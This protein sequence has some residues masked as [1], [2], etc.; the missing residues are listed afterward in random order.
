M[1]HSLYSRF[2]GTLLGARVGT[3]LSDREPASQGWMGASELVTAC[4]IERGY[5]RLEDWKHLQKLLNIANN[6][7]KSALLPEIML[8]L[9]PLA[10]FFHDTPSLFG[11]QL[12]Q[13]VQAWQLS[14]EEWQIL[15]GWGTLLRLILLEKITPRQ[16]PDQW[17]SIGNSSA[18]EQAIALV[19][20]AWQAGMPLTQLSRQ[21]K[22]YV[23][24]VQAALPL[25]LYCWG[26]TPEDFRLS[27]LRSRKI[28][29]EPS[30]ALTGALSGAYN[31]VSGIFLPWCL[32][33]NTTE[34]TQ[35]LAYQLPR[36]WAKWT[37]I[38]ATEELSPPLERAVASPQLLQP[39]LSLKLI[40]HI[41]REQGT[42]NRE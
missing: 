18:F 22:R 25:A 36:L 14:L 8:A 30:V 11:E 34:M 9:L 41:N 17:Q 16:I 19:E 12:E 29:F 7:Q 20:P 4:V 6:G 2:Q 15:Q 37:G 3:I 40:S 32:A 28:G 21:L 5:L 33:L 42:G 35:T 26:D 1:K 13:G 23:S 27:V 31:S 24:P 39:R 10:V 38:N